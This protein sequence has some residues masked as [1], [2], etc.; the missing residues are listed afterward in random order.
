MQLSIEAIAKDFPA[1]RVAVVRA[2]GLDFSAQ[3]G[4]ALADEIAAAEAAALS[5]HSG[6]ELSAIDPLQDWRRAYKAFGVKKT[7]YRCS[8]E[9]LLKAVLAGRG[10]PRVN[11]LVDC[12][13]LISLTYLL[14]VGADDLAKT[15]GPLAFR[16]AREG[17]DFYA[18][19]A[20]EARDDPPKPG[21]VVYADGE[22]LLC[23]RWNW[24]QDARSATSLTTR[25]A[26]I[27]VQHLGEA[28]RLEAAVAELCDWLGRFCSASCAW[29]IADAARPS[30][31]VAL[32]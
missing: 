7:S 8:A 29:R 9:R 16:Y 5:R 32:P 22:K 1:F 12:Y 18:L 19:G 24:Y 27:T 26:A 13:N 31:E 20:A 25:R 11:A 10:L 6:R 17:D 14:P 28:A 4:D 2:A 21:E 23:R 15:Q 30:V 3:R